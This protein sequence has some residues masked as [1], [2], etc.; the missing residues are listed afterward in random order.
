[1]AR[2]AGRPQARWN[3]GKAPRD[4]VAE[5]SIRPAGR[6]EDFEK[7]APD[8]G[9]ATAREEYYQLAED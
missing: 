4:T 9:R 5:D 8:P 3:A 6:K 2:T 1:L 7:L